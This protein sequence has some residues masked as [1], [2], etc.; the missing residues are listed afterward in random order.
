M[1]MSECQGG[2]GLRGYLR[3]DLIGQ[4]AWKQRDR[5]SEKEGGVRGG[6]DL[7]LPP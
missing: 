5:Y 7:G 2:V 6:V 1:F 3:W 4:L